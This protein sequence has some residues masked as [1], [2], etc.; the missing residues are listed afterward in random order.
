[1]KKVKTRI[2]SIFLTLIM[3]FCNAFS[4]SAEMFDSDLIDGLTFNSLTLE[5]LQ[6]LNNGGR[7]S[8]TLKSELPSSPSASKS[9]SL[10]EEFSLLDMG[11]SREVGDQGNLGT[12]W[13]FSALNSSEMCLLQNNLNINLSET[14]LSWFSYNTED[15]HDAFEYIFS[16]YDPYLNGGYDLTAANA[17]ANWYGPA[18]EENFPYSDSAINEEER[19]NCVAHLQNVI[20]FPEFEYEDEQEQYL[21]VQALVELVKGE[22][23]RTNQSVDISYRAA[24]SSINFNPDTN[25]WFNP[26]ERDT[27]HAVSIVGWDDNFSKENFNN[28]EMIENDG[29]WLVQNSWGE[30]WGDNGY[31]W[32]SYEDKTVDYNGIYLYESESNHENI[33]SHDESIQYT[34]I[35]F[36]DSTEIYM[37]NVFESEGAEYLEAVSFYTT[38]VNTFYKVEIYTGLTDS[39]N[40]TSGKL[41]DSFFGVKALP[42]YYTED[43]AN[44]VSL[45]DGEK[46]SVVVYVSNPTQQFTSQV[47]AIYMEYRIQSDEDVSQ[48]GESFVSTDGEEW[49]DIYRKLIKGFDGKA[50]MRLGNFT[51]KAFTSND[52][53]VSFSLDSGEVSL[54]EKLSMECCKKGEIYYTL[55]G[56]DPRR[57]GILYTSPIEI[58][59]GVS[60]KASVK[61]NGIFGEVYSRQFFQ[62]ATELSTLCF[63]DGEEFFDV[64]ISK[65]LLGNFVVANS[66]EEITVNATSIFNIRINGT[67]VKSGDDLVLPLEKLKSNEIEIEITEDGYKTHVY[68]ANVIVNPISYDYEKETI[69]FDDKAISVKTKYY[70][71]V[72]NGQ[73]VKQWLDSSNRMTFLVLIDGN[74]ESIAMPRRQSLPVPT[75]DY[76]N[77]RSVEKYGV[78]V[79]YKTSEEAEFDIENSVEYDYL[80]LFPG[81]TMYFVRPAQGGM[82]ASEVVSMKVPDR[83][84]VEGI[85]VEEVKRTKIKITYDDELVYFCENANMIVNGIYSDLRPGEEYVLSVY[86]PAS[87]SSFKSET[88]LFE[89][90]TETDESFEKMKKLIAASEKEDASSLELFKAFFARIFYNLRLFFVLMFE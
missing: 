86:K 52:R 63:F 34:P 90:V 36:E 1:M 29:A 42:G 37:A 4:A 11:F 17:L 75:I 47:E 51:I 43:L 28:S 18:L 59:D 27:N 9:Q 72:E 87:E 81:E 19:Y 7:I 82:F 83:P 5:Q 38:D 61:I 13:A 40:P 48:P 78:R 70:E 16:E 89:V 30:D 2:L 85:S 26:V 10:P 67:E 57:N 44:E 60:V 64:D 21:A 46:F 41:A 20:S 23:Y 12:C 39:E 15:Q 56:S 50:Y 35:G 49:T 25:A 65:E 3:L 74:L 24:E 69:H 62:A 71:A 6:I 76:E 53:Y 8:S 77:E 55:D 32:L 84:N 79:C 14:H 80:P 68:T 33:Y 31:F 88:Y 54:K 66:A 45:S 73:S 22:M 58:Y